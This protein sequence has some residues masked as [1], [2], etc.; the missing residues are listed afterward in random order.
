[1][2]KAQ[3]RLELQQAMAEPIVQFAASLAAAWVAGGLIGA[4][5]TFHG[6]AGFRTHSLVAIAAAAAVLAG[7]GDLAA[8]SRLGQGVITGIGFL[9]AGVIF[10]EGVNIQGLT[11]AASVWATAA[12]GLLFGFGEFTA[13][14]VVTVAVFAVLV[15]LRWLEDA[16]PTRVYAWSTFR[17]T[18]EAAPTENGLR[19]VLERHG[20]TLREVSYA[21]TDGG[22]T[23]E[24]RGVV[25]APAER[26]LAHLADALRELEGLP[27]F[28]LS[29]IS[30]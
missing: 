17:F 16:I 22:A 4:E 24:F 12:I 27:E 10:K 29:R 26:V 8:M 19:V 15:V 3:L 25:G 11:T 14:A 18:A 6:R 7:Q 2:A 5:R 9:G 13:G 21:R 30:K 1:M 28:E 23:V 20:V